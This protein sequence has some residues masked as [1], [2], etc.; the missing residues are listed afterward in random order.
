MSGADL[1][2]L[3]IKCRVSGENGTIR[4]NFGMTGNAPLRTF[5]V[6]R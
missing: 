5:T 3:Y 4:I 6:M 2:L 1:V